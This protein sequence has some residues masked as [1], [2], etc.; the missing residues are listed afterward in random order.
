MELSINTLVVL[1]L[2]I[3]VVGGGIALVGS[4]IAETEDLLPRIGEAEQEQLVEK[5][6]RGERVVITDNVKQGTYGDYTFGLG[7]K[8]S[9]PQE[10]NFTVEITP[11]SII[12][13]DGDVRSVDDMPAAFYVDEE[14]TLQPGEQHTDVLFNIDIEKGNPRG[15]Y[16]YE[17][18][19][20]YK[21]DNDNLVSY[22]DP[23]QVM[24]TIQ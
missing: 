7:F 22:A 9:L 12:E 20:K 24:I 21:N 16:T 10:R 18:Q 5:L 1:I 19:I 15:T 4:I 2:G 17:V 11:K 13:R 14:I 6:Q 23:L 8:N 3:L